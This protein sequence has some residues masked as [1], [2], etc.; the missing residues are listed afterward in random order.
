ML[1]TGSYKLDDI[2]NEI[3]IQMFFNRDYDITNNESYIHI[4]GNTAELK[5]IVLIKNNTYNVDFGRK[6]IRFSSKCFK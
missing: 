4:V 1:E 6:V 5:S 2:N 3:E